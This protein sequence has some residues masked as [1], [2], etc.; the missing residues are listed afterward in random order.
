M[1]TANRSLANLLTSNW[2]SLELI[3]TLVKLA[4]TDVVADIK[5]VLLRGAE[6]FPEI[7]CLALAQLK[8][9]PPTSKLVFALSKRLNPLRI[10]SNRGPN[11]I[12]TFST[13]FVTCFFRATPTPSSSSKS[14][15]A[16][17]TK[18]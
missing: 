3:E 15:G 6:Q 17:A 8:V 4:E 13:T 5:N 14:F 10:Y 11:S 7:V 2:N 9:R 18:S 1:V 12:G 16:G